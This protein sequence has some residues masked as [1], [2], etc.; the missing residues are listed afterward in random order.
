MNDEDQNLYED[1]ESSDNQDRGES[2]VH[3]NGGKQ[4]LF[5]DGVFCVGI[6]L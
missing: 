4:W 5:L 6:F 3:M 1:Q 2:E